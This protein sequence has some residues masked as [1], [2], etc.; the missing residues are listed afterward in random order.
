MKTSRTVYVAMA[1]R[2]RRLPNFKGKVRF[3]LAFAK[4]LGINDDHTFVEATLHRPVPYQ[5]GL[6]LF[7]KHELMAYLMDGYE[8][9]TVELLRKLW[10]PG[11][12]LL[13]IGANIGLVGIPFTL[14]CCAELSENSAPLPPITYCI[15]AAKANYTSLRKNII[16]NSLEHQ[17]VLLHYALGDAPRQV[18]IQL[19]KD[20]LVDEGTGTA[21]IIP[22]NQ[23]WN[24]RTSTLA[25]TT[26]DILIEQD[27][28]PKSCSLIKI[29][30]GRL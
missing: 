25:L 15:E 21:N 1:E 2:L 3:L 10:H 24:C 5:I 26:I 4:F 8:V 19:E 9:K 6:D 30:L 29:G 12:I 17:I 13:D 16:L 27:L 22:T 18:E 7:C 28:L 14:E 23:N 11:D 20:Q